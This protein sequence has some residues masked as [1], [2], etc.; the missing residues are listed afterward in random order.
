MPSRQK[1]IF[2]I[3]TFHCG[4]TFRENGSCRWRFIRIL[5]TCINAYRTNKRPY[6]RIMNKKTIIYEK[7]T[8]I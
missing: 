3:I 5:Y 7:R 6:A 2:V 4:K 8:L 1:R